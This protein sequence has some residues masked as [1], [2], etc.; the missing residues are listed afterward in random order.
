M[1]RPMGVHPYVWVGVCM[2]MFLLMETLRV[3]YISLWERGGALSLTEHPLLAKHSAGKIQRGHC[4][5]VVLNSGENVRSNLPRHN[6]KQFINCYKTFME[7]YLA[8]DRELFPNVHDYRSSS[9]VSTNLS[10]RR[11]DECVWRFTYK[12]I[13]PS[14]SKVIGEKLIGEKN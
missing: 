6:W 10:W 5:T 11:N 13:H 1:R 12:D 4:F 8:T 9:F 3:K 14:T 7:G 2:W